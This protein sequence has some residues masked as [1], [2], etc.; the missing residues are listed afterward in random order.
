MVRSPNFEGTFWM[1][2]YLCQLNGT[3][4]GAA[5]ECR[6]C[7]RWICAHCE[8]EARTC[9]ACR[10][11]AE[12]AAQLKRE[13]EALARQKAQWCD[14]C[15]QVANSAWSRNKKCAKCSRQFC[16]E[17]G[18]VIWDESDRSAVGWIRCSDHLEFPSKLGDVKRGTNLDL[19]I[20][21]F[22][23]PLAYLG[24]GWLLPAIFMR[25]PDYYRRRGYGERWTTFRFR[26]FTWDGGWKSDERIYDFED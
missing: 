12:R 15:G 24:L 16:R 5:L 4:V 1:V 7:R 17:H 23:L 26:G 9:T 20:I 22:S 19:L 8:S 18:Q 14:L 2:C 10:T 13:A 21:F 3:E 6:R 11:A 25:K